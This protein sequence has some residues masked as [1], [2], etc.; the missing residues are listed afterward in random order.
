MYKIRTSITLDKSKQI[1][2]NVEI[3]NSL[4]LKYVL[5]IMLLQLSHFPSF[6]LLCPAHPLPPKF[7]ALVH[8]HGSYI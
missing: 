1:F 4:F 8:V 3:E 7:P 6:I 2:K 5:L